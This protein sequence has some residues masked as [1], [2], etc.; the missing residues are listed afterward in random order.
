MRVGTFL[1]LVTGRRYWRLHSLFVIVAMRAYGIRVGKRFYCEGT[2][3]LKVAGRGANIVIGDGVSFLGEVDLRNRENGRIVIED[4]VQIET[5]VRIVSAREGTVRVGEGSSIGAYSI[6]NGGDD[7]TI[8][9]RCAISVRVSINSNEHRTA[10]EAFIRDQA[11]D[12]APVVIGDDV[13]LGANAAVNKGVTIGRGSVVGANAVVTK[14][15]EE[16]SINVGVPARTIG[17]RE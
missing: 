8:G 10:R 4:G 7:I 13:L 11:F 17:H 3:R 6:I 1:A 15:T 2:P 12:L 9:R 16:Y 14:D 5:G